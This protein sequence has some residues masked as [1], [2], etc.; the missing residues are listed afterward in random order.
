[1]VMP[2]ASASLADFSL[3]M[4]KSVEEQNL[5]GK[6]EFLTKAIQ[7]LILIFTKSL[8]RNSDDDKQ[9]TAAALIKMLLTQ[10]RVLSC[11]NVFIL[12][13]S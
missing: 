3:M 13:T 10:V 12:L 1:M 8:P 9:E 6:N 4:S 5:F 11:S 7:E 2:N